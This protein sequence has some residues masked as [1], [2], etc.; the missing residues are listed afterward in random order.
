MKILYRRCA[1]MDVHKKSISV[2]VRRREQGQKEAEI[3]EAVFGTFTQDLERLGEWLKQRWCGAFVGCS[4]GYV[5]R[6]L[7]KEM[8]HARP[9]GFS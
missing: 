1:G 7:Q 3:E 4:G 8:G 2:C 6:V 9:F 5:L